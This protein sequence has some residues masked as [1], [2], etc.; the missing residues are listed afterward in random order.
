ML[1]TQFPG[2]TQ[3]ARRAIGEY[4]AVSLDRARKKAREWH[5][6]I[7]K[8]IDPA[9]AEEEERRGSAKKAGQHLCLGGREIS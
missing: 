3:P 2:S 1:Q 5:E 8:G 6:L 4:D 9:I 7:G